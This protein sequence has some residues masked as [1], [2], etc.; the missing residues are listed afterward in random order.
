MGLANDGMLQKAVIEIINEKPEEIK[1]TGAKEKNMPGM[2]TKNLNNKAANALKNQSVTEASGSGTEK[3][4][5]VV[6]FNP[7]ELRITAE[8]QQD[9]NTYFADASGTG[10]TIAANPL[11]SRARVHFKLIF[12]DTDNEDAFQS[13]HAVL[14]PE[15]LKKGAGNY[16]KTPGQILRARE[17]KRQQKERTVRSQVE[18]IMAALRSE[19]KRKVRFIWGNLSYS[20]FLNTIQAEYTM[21]NP[22]GSPVR[23]EVQIG[24]LCMDAKLEQGNMGQWHKHYENLTGSLKK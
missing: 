6:Q 14:H 24:I 19:H 22:E 5:F 13:E 2:N 15:E 7:S 16:L 23:A 9:S 8:G 11:S 21:F 20:G 12:D 17:A 18:G 10:K 3:V 1:V 4:R